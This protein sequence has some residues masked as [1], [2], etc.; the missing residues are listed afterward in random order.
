[1][2]AEIAMGSAG[3]GAILLT[4]NLL[5]FL[6]ALFFGALICHQAL[7]ADR[8]HESNLTEF[9]L[10]VSAGGVLGG[11][12]NALLAPMLFRLVLE[13]P[14]V[15]TVI[16]LARPSAAGKLGRRDIL[17]AGVGIM[18]VAVMALIPERG[19]SHATQVIALLAIAA[20]LAAALASRRASLFA[21]VIG[22]LCFEAAIVVPDKNA[23]L[24]TI[25]SFFGV[26]RAVVLSDSQLGGEVH[27][28]F[29]GTTIHG[30]QAVAPDHRC[31]PGTYYAPG[32]PLREGIVAMQRQK[33]SVRIAVVGLGTGTIA[34]FTRAADQMR[35]F[36]I[37]P[38]VARIASD[39]KYF[40]Y[41]SEC[42]KG[43]VDIAL[44]D[45]RLT[46]AREPAGKF[47][48]V[49]LDA[50]SGDNI[51]THLLTREA[52][53]LYSRVLKPDGIALLHITNRNLALE[54][55]AAATAKAAGFDARVMTFR[56][57]KEVSDLAAASSTAMLLSKTAAIT[58][59]IAENPNW[60]IP[61]DRG[62]RPWTDEY[63]NIAG[64]LYDHIVRHFQ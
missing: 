46:L 56:S 61:D 23:P 39:P 15:L 10:L 11:V 31:V 6:G 48:M 1:M 50:F 22:A 57:P 29:H 63:T 13:F 51:P 2:A 21:L 47:D 37:D 41:L 33:P 38:A 16:C 25:R 58:A 3:S 42:A 36:E 59:M 62:V 32:T 8:P 64:A 52:F 18:T 14:L 17:A 24:V 45:A 9:Y 49:I 35:Y 27:V 4:L 5:V 34:A 12:F 20:G 7:A 54:A 53:A 55:P 44:G 30:S 60:H 43:K 28:L 19:F 26:S 40:T